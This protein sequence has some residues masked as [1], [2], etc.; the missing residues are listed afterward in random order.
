MNRYT[1]AVLTAGILLMSAG[2][3]S[4]QT[5]GKQQP[6][7]TPTTS[8]PAPIDAP[9]MGVLTVGVDI[10]PGVYLVREPDSPIARYEGTG[11]WYRL[12]CPQAPPQNGCVIEHGKVTNGETGTLVVEPT[13]T[14]L[15]IT[16]LKLF[17]AGE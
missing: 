2:C 12:D 11:Y 17:P 9:L 5:D 1:Q 15:D 16:N 13:D 3:S 6:P 8:W 10:E 14:A 4:P 7:I